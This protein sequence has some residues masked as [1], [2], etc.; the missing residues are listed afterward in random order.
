MAVFIGAGLAWVNLHSEMALAAGITLLVVLFAYDQ[1][2]QRSGV[3]SLAFAAVSGMIL[4]VTLY[5]VK[6]WLNPTPDPMPG[7]FTKYL[8][9]LIWLCATFANF[10]LDR[11]R[12]GARVSFSLRQQQIAMPVV[13]RCTPHC[14]H[15]GCADAD[16]E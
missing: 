7:F 4:M 3:Q 16:C 11:A 13:R 8:A 5:P 1:D 14:S 12:M 6:D 9:L 2:A 10:L 15:A